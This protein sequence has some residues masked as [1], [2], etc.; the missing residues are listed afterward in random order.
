MNGDWSGIF[1]CMIS[2]T[3]FLVVGFVPT[4]QSKMQL[5]E[6]VISYLFVCVFFLLYLLKGIIEHWMN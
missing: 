2:S 5:R 6:K 1:R 4:I 3:I